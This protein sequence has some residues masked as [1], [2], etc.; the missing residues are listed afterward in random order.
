MAA[1]EHGFTWMSII[2]GLDLLPD[3]TATAG[4]IA[5]GILATA[6]VARRQLAGAAD[7]AVPDGT[8]TARNLMEIFVEGFTSLVEGVVGKDARLYAPFYGA[9]FLFILC[10]NLIGL[11][12]GFVPPTSNANTTLGLGITS[13][14]AFNYFGFRRH[15]AAYLR[16]FL[17]PIWWLVPLMLPLELIDVLLRPITLNLRLLMNMF[18][19]HLVLDIFT[20]LT[21]VIVPV[22]FYMLGTFVSIVQAFVFTLLSLVYVALAVGGHDEEHAHGPKG[23]RARG[24]VDPRP[25]PDSFPIWLI[26][27][28]R[29]RCGEEDR[30]AWPGSDPFSASKGGNRRCARRSGGCSER[31]RSP[32]SDRAWH[33]PRRPGPRAAVTDISH[34][35]PVSGSASRRSAP[36]S[37]R[38]V[39][40]QRP[41]NRLA[42]IPTLPIEFKPR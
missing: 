21:R 31:R 6:Y 35:R 32:C 2:P 23:S 17:G 29:P 26:G 4:L 37:G 18:A 8:Y 16:H 41:W 36:G 15:G 33:S 5:G 20:D 10:C 40:W 28:A 25:E 1:P 38:A 12:P 24:R 27:F 42:E 19:D 9:L 14:V 30:E 13:F 7:P 22:V 3:H 34:W 39:R 11:L